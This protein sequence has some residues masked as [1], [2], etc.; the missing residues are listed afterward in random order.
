[1]IANASVR[2]PVTVMTDELG[3][4]V[5]IKFRVRQRQDSA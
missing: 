3:G 1:M 2:G 4:T 5:D